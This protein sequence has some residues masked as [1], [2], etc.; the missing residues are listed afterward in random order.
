MIELDFERIMFKPIVLSHPSRLMRH[1]VL[2]KIIPPGQFLLCFYS[3][4]ELKGS[5]ERGRSGF[6]ANNDQ[7]YCPQT[8][9]LG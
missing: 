4:A 9:S 6:G 2:L 5:I 3:I 8:P 7:K 1:T